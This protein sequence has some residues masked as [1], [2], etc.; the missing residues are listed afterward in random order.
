MRIATERI[1]GSRPE[2]KRRA[3][4]KRALLI[5]L[6]FLTILG[7]TDLIL[8][9]RISQRLVVRPLI[10][11]YRAVSGMIH[12][13]DC[14]SRPSCSAYALEAYGRHGLILGTLLTVDRLL[15]ET[16]RMEEGPWVRVEGRRY[17]DDPLAANTFWWPR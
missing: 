11:V 16:G 8:P 15:G 12:E 4:R 13:H 7:G 1:G 14:P 17:V 5:L 9:A 2:R 10:S 6:L 3:G